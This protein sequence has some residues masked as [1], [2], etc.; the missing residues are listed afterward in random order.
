MSF[1]AP[2]FFVGLAAVGVPILV[3]LIQRERKDV[4]EFPSL[5]F[6]RQIPFQSVERRRL[7]NWPLLLLRLAA[8][9]LLVIAF[10]RPFF[11]RETVSAAG[12]TGGAREVV[13]LLDRSASMGYGDHWARAQEEARQVV[14]S[15]S[16]DDQATLVLFGAGVEEAIR[17]T[18]N[19]GVL[20]AGIDAAEVTAD[21]TRYGPALR[22]A[23]SILS[24][25]QLPRKQA[26]LIT[27][28]QRSGWERRE[29]V[30]LPEG[31]ELVP[32]SVASPDMANLSVSTVTFQRTPFSGQERIAVTAGVTNRGTRDLTKLPVRLEVDGRVID[33]R[34]VDVGAHASASVT[35]PPVTVDGPRKAAV[36]AGEDELP[37]DN[38]FDF[39]LAPSRPLSVL[40]VQ[41]DGVSTSGASS[42]SV[43]LSSAF[44][45]AVEP[46]IAAEVMPVSRVTRESFEGRAV[47][48][49]NDVPPLGTTADEALRRFVDQ[50]G[51]LLVAV[52]ER[53]PW[54][55]ES[56]L[57]PGRLGSMIDRR[58]SLGTLGFLDFS[59][60]VF[61]PFKDPRN[62][63]F[64]NVRFHRYRRLEPAADDRVLARFDDGAV[65]M[66]ERRVGSGRVILW[67]TT[68]DR[69]WNDFPARNLFPVV[70]PAVVSYLAQYEPPEAWYTVGRTLDIS[71]PVAALVREG[72]AGGLSAAAAARGVVLSPSGRQSTIGEGGAAAVTLSEQGFYSVRLQGGGDRRPFEIAVNV[73]PAESDLSGLAPAEFVNT[74]TG[75]VAM[76]A[77]G[78]SLERPELTPADIEK[79]Q[80]LWWFLFLAAVVALVGE[81]VLSNRQSQRSGAGPGLAAAGR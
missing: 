17:A 27:D 45:I 18:A 15:L 35:F 10:S 6:I 20:E 58:T 54:T 34:T 67:T 72:G 12:A 13:I 14:R 60:P 24:R 38:T 37:V 9:T 50:G 7:H 23:Q 64:A 33:T 61:E 46:R 49:L 65:A 74:A 4:I 42:P 41:P 28:F 53:Q 69:G 40:I 57:L 68:L 1:L 5:M 3:H 51:G 31:A 26:V 2:L 30:S 77:S 62:G 29:E 16:G 78:Q 21:S 22:L 80:G 52:A 36:V 66:V 71:V 43:Y 8:M 73:D 47:V 55:G 56:P 32:I 44:D 76:T 25:S 75:A 39:I 59:H 63:T 11:T 81:A 19:Q 70:A 79:K 48:V